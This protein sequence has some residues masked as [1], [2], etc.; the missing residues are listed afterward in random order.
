MAD[1]LLTHRDNLFFSKE[2]LKRDLKRK[3]VRG[4]LIRVTANGTSAALTMGSAIVLARLLKPEEFGLFAMVAVITQFARSFMELGLGT[5][6]VQRDEITHEEVSTLFW[7]NLGVG[8]ILMAAMAGLSPAVA[9]FYGDTRLFHVCMVLSTVFVFGGLT[10]QH[11]SLLERQMRFSYLGV[12]YVASTLI[13]I[14]V[15]IAL[16]LYGFGFWA[17]VWRDLAAVAL[18]AAGTWVLCGWIPGLPRW[19]A[20]VRS[21]L[22]FG[23]DV[24]G[25]SIVQYFTQN[26]DRVLI[27]RFCGAT[28]LG[29]YAKALQLAMMPI[30]HIRM[31]IL[32]VGLSPLSALQSD[33]ERYRRFYSRLL[34]V[35]SFLYM[36]FVVFIAIQSEDVIRLL[37]GEAWVS[38]APL[39]RIF[40]IA[41]FVRPIVATYQLVM[42][43]CGKTRRYLLWGMVNSVCLIA[44]FAIGIGW[45]AI[46]VSYGYAFASY[47]ILVWSS[48]YCFKDTPVSAL[49][50][51][52][53]ILLPV[54]SSC[55]AGIILVALRPSISNT[56]LL[57]SIVTSFL[58]VVVV[59]LGIYLC[60]PNGRQK[61]SEFWSYRAEL[62]RTP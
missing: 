14:C 61:L 45:G 12:I 16:A 15:A 24:S 39:L 59:Y 7:V 62:F 52:K 41:G 44:A 46:G 20:G 49:L 51:I 21:S 28:P 50:V 25:F 32:G 17:L 3:S 30:E 35:L 6:T 5:A 54:M 2:Q 22:R 37:L 47:A 19:N 40:A 11:R 60:I 34:S 27:G 26:L 55:G 8:I 31:T 42:I 58:L 18:Y 56:S 23:A 53:T 36:P 4:T 9:W 29:L 57:V 48:W 43:S 10:V 1:N 38:A 33:A 13:S